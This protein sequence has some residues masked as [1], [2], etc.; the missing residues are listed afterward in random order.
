MITVLHGENVVASRKELEQL[1]TEFEDEV[2]SLDGKTLTETDFIQATQSNSLLADNRLVIVENPDKLELTNVSC[3][4]ILWFDKELSKAQTEKYKGA[5]IQGFKIEPKIFKFCDEILPRSGPKLTNLFQ[6][7][8]KTEEPE[9]VF[10]MI[11]RQFRLM[12]N[13]NMALPWQKSK[14]ISQARAFEPEKLKAI[15]KN[16]L[17]LDFKAK[18]G[19]LSKGLPFALELFLLSL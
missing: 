4:L 6:E 18:T 15:Y 14:I 19:Q 13:P 16:L 17:D 9:F 7:L 5:K 3:D 10:V 8:L 11:V 1:K 2:V 12:L